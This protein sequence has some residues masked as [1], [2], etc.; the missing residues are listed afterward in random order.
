MECERCGQWGPV[1]GPWGARGVSWGSRGDAVGWPWGAVGIRAGPWG[2]CVGVGGHCICLRVRGVLVD[3]IGGEGL[4]VHRGEGLLDG[5]ELDDGL[6]GAFVL[7]G[8]E[9][10]S[11]LIPKSST[12]RS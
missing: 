7:D 6:I 9:R 5:W 3:P 11:P 2:L 8:Q 10:D 4:L 1:G 12:Y